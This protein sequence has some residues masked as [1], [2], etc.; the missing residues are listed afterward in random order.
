MLPFGAV[1]LVPAFADG[2]SMSHSSTS[3]PTFGTD[4]VR[5]VANTEITPELAM[6]LGRATARVLI[7][8][9]RVGSGRPTIYI[10]ADTRQSGPL[11]ISSFGAGAMAEGADVIVLGVVPTPAVAWVAATFQ[12]PAAMV[13]ASH[14]P[15][16]D[17][18]IK[19]FAA[20]GRKLSDDV[21]HR[22]EAELTAIL[23]R[24]PSTLP[25][26][27]TGAA[28]GR[29]VPDHD[30]AQGYSKHVAAT[31]EG[32]R[33]GGITVVLDCA[34]GSASSVAAEIFTSLGASV[35][36]LHASPNGV[37]INAGCG[38][39]HPESLAEAVRSRGADLGLAFDG[40]ADRC[41][42]I[43]ADGNLIDGDQ[44]MAMLALDLR[45]RGQLADDTV[46][47][48][49]MTNLG[50]KLAVGDAGLKIV[51]TK[52]GDRYVL[53]ALEAG[54]Y[55]LG[56]EQSGHVIMTKHASTGD[57]VLTGVA[58][59][60]LMVRSGRTLADLGSVME[61][62][63]QV[64]INVKGVDRAK[65]DGAKALWA[66]VAAVEAELAGRGR[67]LLRPSGT[68]ALVRVMVEAPTAELAQ[69]AAER[70]VDSVRRDLS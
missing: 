38:S 48:T 4:G 10:G 46:V 19:L 54:G 8:P 30:L 25:D 51:E 66:D 68:E 5:G 29:M 14:N 2:W 63:P 15:F 53:D 52:V 16:A 43:D 20:G 67:V 62:L 31:V 11:L 40:D 70:L 65:L 64:L 33:L 34:N 56:G 59:C 12:A 6:A 50:F 22:L 55:S 44:I 37:N 49:V 21:E 1:Q 27:P 26:G 58:I 60:D 45:A 23:A 36:V 41:L 42:A 32:R 61:R 17:N 13:S 69:S 3:L 57:G 7:D 24:T 35:T 18:G 9:A 47:V 28:V 39:T